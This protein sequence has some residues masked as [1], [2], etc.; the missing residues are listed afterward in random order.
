MPTITV[1]K[2]IFEKLVGKK[3]P[4]DQLKD[5]I[6]YLG[7]D[8]EDVKDNE[9]IVE[10]FPDR[11]DMLSV[12]G[13]ARAF[14]SFIGVKTGLR[15]YNV[16][17]SNEKVIID[18]SLKNIRPY[19]AC[20]IVKNLKF[21]NDKIKEVIQIQEKLHVTYG[22]NRRKV[23]LGIYPFEKIKTP[24]RFMAMKPEDIKFQPLEFP[25]VINGRQI[26]S[27]HPTGREYSHLLEGYEKYPIFIDANN[28]VLSM[29][30][31]I[32]SHDTGKITEK[33]KDVFI[34]CSGF[35]F[36]TLKKCLNMVVTALADIGG[37]IYSME[38]HYGNE[39]VLTPNLEHEIMKLEPKYVNKIL[40][41]DLKE[42]DIKKYLERMGYSYNNKKVL[43]PSYRADV[44]HPIDLVEDVAIAYGFENF[45]EEIPIISTIGEEKEFERFKTKI[46]DF[47]VGFNLFETNTYNL[48]NK[49]D[50]TTNCNLNLDTV[51]IANSKTEYNSLRGWIIPSLLR[52]LRENKHNE[53]PQRIFEIGTTFKK[54]IQEETNVEENSRLA[55]L[56]C[57]RKADYT[58]IKQ[59]LDSLL[60]SLKLKYNIEETEHGSF[61]PGRVGRVIVN[62]K[63]V[64]YIG[65]VHPQVLANFELDMPVAAF[66]LNI[67]E[68]F[69]ILK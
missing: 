12:E 9:I 29:P 64:A 47:M 65:E 20:A 59:I 5:R 24:I 39:K 45:K 18:S 58:E 14:S 28:K 62:G 67:S 23:A 56:L 42:K 34:E 35:D 36:N 37:E 32:N 55:V 40:G 30:P 2:D 53:Y 60:T 4:L 49:V 27:Q 44:L 10:I 69:E 21:D 52:V 68:L 22:R 17:K 6:S 63:K 26:L 31:I 25:H 61:I 3:L 51:E 43:I 8:L 16:R 11:P 48:I 19:T 13:F 57:H 41:M 66:E 15:K 38:L 50:Q 7:T 46:A 1:N 54:N 33:T